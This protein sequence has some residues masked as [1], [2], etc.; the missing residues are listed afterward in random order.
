MLLEVFVKEKLKKKII[1]GAI[2]LAIGIGGT[3]A[4]S[5]SISTINGG[6]GV[7]NY[8][9]VATETFTA[10]TNWQ[11]GET[12][13]FEVTV[14]NKSD[15]DIDT[16]I[17][18]EE[19][20]VTDEGEKLPLIS[21][22]SGL[23]MAIVD[24]PDDSGWE[25]EGDYYVYDDDLG[26]GETTQPLIRSVTLNPDANL[27]NS[28]ED[29][30]GEDAP[31]AGAEYHLKV[32]IETVQ[33]E[34]K[35]KWYSLYD[36]VA[37]RENDLGDY[38]VDLTARSSRYGSTVAERNG[39]GVNAYT[40]DGAKIYY[41]RGM[42]DDN[43]VIWGNHCWKI[44]RT[45]KT[46]GVKIYYH[47]NPTYEDGVGKCLTS[48]DDPD[49]MIKNVKFNDGQN[50]PSDVGYMY[51]DRVEAADRVP[52]STETFVFSNNVS[53]NGDS[54]TLDTSDGQSI[55]G[56]WNSLRETASTR[57]H[58]FCTN[59]AASCDN[60]QIGYAINYFNYNTP[61]IYYLPVGG[62][63]DIEAMKAA[64]FANEHDSRIKTELEA[65]F[66]E[67]NLDGHIDGTRNYED[68]LEDAV[69]C[70]D[71]SY[72]SGALV[73][74]D[75]SGS[76]GYHTTY[77]RYNSHNFATYIPVLECPNARDAFTKD[78]ANGNGKLKHK[79]GLITADELQLGGL[80]EGSAFVWSLYGGW[81]MT[82]GAF[83]YN[84]AQIIKLNT[85]VGYAYDAA[86]QQG[87]KPVVSLKTGTTYVAGGDGTK[88]NPYVIE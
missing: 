30:P 50:S 64:M 86:S 1:L 21:D 79:I 18:V 19:E 9:T 59:G 62:Y 17:K 70:N 84:T 13:P 5:Q 29:N 69:Y 11:P 37:A 60:T 85:Y 71:R 23:E 73:G 56:T 36:A 51:G 54:Y 25:K 68:D 44:L 10:P 26:P 7:A 43:F 52:T 45:T 2:V 33:P 4:I 34:G 74:K 81:T 76:A 83:Q 75:A 15:V 80:V 78:S 16:R 8:E 12:T 65:W 28:D 53:R 77:S 47:G 24:Y 48:E 46:G 14:E 27:D 42:I 57:Y 67:E 31:Y 55:S 20:W 40:E 39:N 49:A 82:P 35:K 3:F 22:G 6:F 88:N 32:I 58:Y 38:Q 41:F 87:L 61:H 72:G 63:D 66:E